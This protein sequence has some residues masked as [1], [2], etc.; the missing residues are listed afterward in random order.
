MKV[1]IEGNTYP[2]KEQLKAAGCR[3]DKDRRAWYAESEEVA[4]KARAIVPATPLFN[5]PPPQDLGTADPVELAAKFGRRAVQ[6]AKV[7]SFSVYGMGKGD[8]GKDNGSIRVVR[9]KR[10]VQVARSAR[11]YYSRDMLEDFDMFSAEP[12]GG[13]QWDGVEVEATADESAADNSQAAAKK[14]KED[15]PKA[16]AAVVAK[17]DQ[18]ITTRPAWVSDATLTAEWAKPDMVHTASYPVIHMSDA[19]I[20]YHVPGYF[21][22][23]WDYAPVHRIAPL[24]DELRAEVVAAI[25]ACQQHGFLSAAK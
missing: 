13:Y 22:C 1:Y 12:G 2:V 7:V 20:Y 24:T 18:V 6:G 25:S 3:W 4:T 9:G 19:E 11:R 10:Y 5:S 15:A 23:D 21:A 8:N 17:I 14:A 16:W